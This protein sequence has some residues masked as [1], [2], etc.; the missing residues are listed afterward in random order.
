MSKVA[1]IAAKE[2]VRVSASILVLGAAVIALLATTLDWS[3]D[4]V[5]LV[6]GVWAAVIGAVDSIVLRKKV[7]P[8]DS[9][10]SS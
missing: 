8:V 4:V 6:G 10:T 5:A 2:P 3:G 7:S 1:T 9:S